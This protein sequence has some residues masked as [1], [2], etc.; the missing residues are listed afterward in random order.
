[1][2]EDGW[3][4]DVLMGFGEYDMSDDRP[5]KRRRSEI[6]QADYDFDDE[7]DLFEDEYDEE[8]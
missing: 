5:K 4:L 7:D 3:A 2:V 8:E 6:A 1:M